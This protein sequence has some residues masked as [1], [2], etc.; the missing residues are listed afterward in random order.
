[1]FHAATLHEYMFALKKAFDDDFLKAIHG[2][3][4]Q[5]ILLLA[6]A[7]T[8]VMIYVFYAVVCKS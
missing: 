4:L 8:A 6:N 1:M 7:R 2:P 3:Q 5:G